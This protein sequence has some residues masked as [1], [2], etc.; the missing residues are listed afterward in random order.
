MAETRPAEK[1][2]RVHQDG[3]T[4]WVPL[5]AW[6]PGYRPR[7]L[8]RDLRAG[9]LVAVLLIPQAMAY[10][11]LA[12]LSPE[13]GLWAAMVPPL[14]Y[15][16]FGTSRFLSVGPVA[17]VSLM[18]GQAISQAAEVTGA[19]PHEAALTLALLVGIALLVVGALRFGGLVDFVSTPVLHGF[20]AGAAV[21]IAGS[22]IGHLLRLEVSR[23]QNF[24]ETIYRLVDHAGEVHLPTLG[25][26]LAA[27]LVLVL[28][29]GPLK[30]GLERVGVPEPWGRWG[31]RFMPLIVV[32]GGIGLVWGLGLS[33]FDVVGPTRAGWPPVS[34]PSLR[35]R[36]IEQL[37][38]SALVIALITFVTGVAVGRS[39]KQDEP[40]AVD[41]SQ[42]LI[43]LGACQVAASLTGG[44]SVGGSFSR[45][46]VASDSGAATPLH[47]L[48]ASALVAAAAVFAGPFLTYL[49]K[50][51]LAA[52]IIVAVG[53]LVDLKAVRRTWRFSRAEGSG[54]L[55]TFVAVLLLG[56]ETGLVLGVSTGLGIYLW[57]ISRPRVVTV[58]RVG[59]SE[60][61]RH[62]GHAHVDGDA[63]SPVLVLR[64]DQDLF[65]ANAR[66]FRE[67][68]LREV[69]S[70]KNGV[71]CVLLDFQA[72]DQIDSSALEI[73][74]ELVE[75]L[76]E[77]GLAMALAEVRQPVMA[78]LEQVE[79][80]ERFGPDRVFGSTHEGVEALESEY[81]E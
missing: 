11:L 14:L 1:L 4:R 46:A 62:T 36:L 53:S 56:V 7:S 24:P 50:A 77:A 41:P 20:A 58:G 5:A 22:Q 63:E 23:G 15:V 70:R 54:M 35:P 37:I 52:L 26:G 68:V 74:E 18:V 79:F 71:A 3:W 19:E 2:A 30:R 31:A 78:R 49:P 66:D 8:L 65:F 13:V 12:D 16:V 9:I 10:A 80:T 73:F 6:L 61:Y 25:L 43:A 40:R 75:E 64:V 33:S 57:R 28:A 39:L 48:F 44:Y 27:L 67:C 60:Q 55:L 32:A 81:G 42:E 72:V 21:L 59:E 47:A 45:S 29:R 51:V 69:T 38:P 34:W 17:L 76:R